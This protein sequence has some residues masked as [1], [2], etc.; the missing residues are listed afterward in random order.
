MYKEN[1][2]DINIL[3]VDDEEIMRNLLFDILKDEGYNVTIASSGKE[4][5]EKLKGNFF[6]IIFID[7]HM[8]GMDGIETLKEI[9]KIN[10]QIKVIMTDSLPTY[11]TE[12]LKKK[13]AIGCIKKPFTIEEMRKAIKEALGV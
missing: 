9:Q 3:V 10:H 13:G 7:V 1:N 6:D 5:I 8:P 11:L 12:E 2:K 4:G